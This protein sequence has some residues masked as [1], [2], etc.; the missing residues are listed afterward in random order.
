M[1]R[2]KLEGKVSLLPRLALTR[3][4]SVS[5]SL[6]ALLV[7]GFIAYKAIPVELMPAGFTPPFMGV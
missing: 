1:I 5:M 6:V 3:P 4:V 2:K 7:V